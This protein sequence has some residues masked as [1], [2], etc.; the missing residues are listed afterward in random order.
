MDGLEPR[1]FIP[2]QANSP[3]TNERWGIR[4]KGGWEKREKAE[5]CKPIPIQRQ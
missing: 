3:I 1:P 2:Y 5:T 4:G